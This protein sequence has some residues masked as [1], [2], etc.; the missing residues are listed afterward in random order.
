MK[1]I[2]ILLS[3][4]LLWAACSNNK[5]NKNNEQKKDTIIQKSPSIDNIDTSSANEVQDLV[6]LWEDTCDTQYY[7]IR[8]IEDFV[9]FRSNEELERYFGKENV[10]YSMQDYGAGWTAY[11]SYVFK[12]YQ[13]KVIVV[14]SYLNDSTDRVGYVTTGHYSPNDSIRMQGGS[15]YT[16]KYG[17]YEGMSLKEFAGLNGKPVVFESLAFSLGHQHCLGKVFKGY[18]RHEFQHYIFHV[19]YSHPAH[20]IPASADYKLLHEFHEVSTGFS[21]DDPRLDLS[22]LYINSIR[23]SPCWCTPY[24]Y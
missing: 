14:W 12:D 22:K 3:F 9:R 5:D 21:S 19:G 15:P 11:T 1:T 13:N 6:A 8:Y 17:L 2:A 16:F 4:T 24:D 7:G 20:T 23:Y 18:L 10:G